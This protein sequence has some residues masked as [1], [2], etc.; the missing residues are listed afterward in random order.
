MVAICDC[1]RVFIVLFRLAV[2]LTSMSCAV[3]NG[4]ITFTT[5]TVAEYRLSDI[6]TSE[7]PIGG[8][9]VTTSVSSTTSEPAVTAV[10]PRL[11]YYPE[12]KIKFEFS[13]SPD[14]TIVSFSV[15]ACKTGLNVTVVDLHEVDGSTNF[16]EGPMHSSQQ[17]FNRAIVTLP[18]GTVTPRSFVVSHHKVTGRV[19]GE[20]EM[21]C[22]TILPNS[23]VVVGYMK[24]RGRTRLD[25]QVQV[26]TWDA[27][28]STL[29]RVHNNIVTGASFDI[30]PPTNTLVIGSS[31]V[32]GFASNQ[33]SAFQEA[34]FFTFTLTPTNGTQLTAM[35]FENSTFVG[36]ILGTASRGIR[37]QFVHFHD[38]VSVRYFDF[39]FRTQ[40]TLLASA[41]LVSN[42]SAT[43]PF[44]MAAHG[45]CAP[46]AFASVV[47]ASMFVSMS[48]SSTEDGAYKL[49]AERQLSTLAVRCSAAM[50]TL[51]PPLLTTPS[52]TTTTMP[53]TTTPPPPPTTT[54]TITAPTRGTAAMATT[55]APTPSNTEESHATANVTT[56][57]SALAST[58]MEMTSPTMT[59]SMTT[60]SIDATTTMNSMTTTTSMAAAPANT[61]VVGDLDIATIGYIVG[62]SVAGLLLLIALLALLL[63]KRGRR[64][65]GKREAGSESQ[66]AQP[67]AMP[68]STIPPSNEHVY[69]D[70][71]DVQRQSAHFYSDV[72][73]VRN[74]E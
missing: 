72:Q 41:T 8:A 69:G 24:F 35:K 32:D 22:T 4:V 62:G 20:D 17:S 21:F 47:N 16:T 59:S 68:M 60:S 1:R 52:T 29:V 53:T 18:L 12:S 66:S 28:E 19:F 63:R 57:A 67:M 10:I 58:S 7:I 39:D 25:F 74:V 65:P 9:F 26:I 40:E 46:T 42:R 44:L 5:G 43:F 37:T 30:L 11:L 23:T 2:L 64:Q 61:N 49:Q 48:L 31:C 71:G 15:V 70:V 33:A 54:T 13:E 36:T 56:T 73:A 38:T 50:I 55:P 27:V 51:L 14:Y 45:L 34:S 6:L 3:R